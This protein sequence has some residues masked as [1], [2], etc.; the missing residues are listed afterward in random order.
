MFLF[1][2][3]LVS[4]NASTAAMAVEGGMK[5]VK[6]LLFFFNFI[7]WVSAI[8]CLSLLGMFTCAG[9]EVQGLFVWWPR[10]ERANKE[11]RPHTTLHGLIVWFDI[12]FC[13]TASF[14][15]LLSFV[16]VSVVIWEI[17]WWA[18]TPTNTGHGWVFSPACWQAGS[19]A[20]V[21]SDLWSWEDMPHLKF[22]GM[23]P[24]CPG[25]H[26]CVLWNVNLM[27]RSVTTSCDSPR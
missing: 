19:H 14:F 10:W 17:S 13:D 25:C 2:A 21:V 3:Y 18:N 12:E 1:C 7:F 8:C 16:N 24:A 5:C 6:F 9:E 11:V 15:Q 26:L 20:C 27:T 23:T 4:G 22:P